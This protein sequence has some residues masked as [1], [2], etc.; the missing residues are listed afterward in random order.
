MLDIQSTNTH[1]EYV[2]RTAFLLQQ[3]L[4]EQ[5]QCYFIRT[6]PV[7]LDTKLCLSFREAMYFYTHDLFTDSS[8]DTGH[9]VLDYTV[10]NN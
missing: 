6:L 3:W 10:S 4:H 9:V 7:L 8:S 5:S 2:I 1:S